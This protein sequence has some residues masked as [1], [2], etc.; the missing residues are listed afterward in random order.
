MLTT[1]RLGLLIVIGL[2]LA[3]AGVAR[4][5]ASAPTPGGTLVVREHQ[6]P[7]DGVYTE[8]YVSFLRV[9]DHTGKVIIRR[10]FDVGDPL[11]HLRSDLAPGTY[12]VTRFIRPCDG[13]C[14]FLD[15]PT[16]RCGHEV[17]IESGHSTVAVAR[18]RVGHAC[19]VR[20]R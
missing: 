16:E 18:T 1:R 5:P 3:A 20:V 2:V 7:S 14:G 13:N 9:R 4:S 17:G 6:R 8:G 12:R 11:V 10:R 19:K 15:P